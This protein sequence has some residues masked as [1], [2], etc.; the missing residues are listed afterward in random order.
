MENKHEKRTNQTDASFAAPASSVAPSDPAPKRY[1]VNNGFDKLFF[2]FSILFI[3]VSLVSLGAS[4]LVVWL[5][6]RWGVNKYVAKVVS[7]AISTTINYLGI[8]T[9]VFR[10]NKNKEDQRDE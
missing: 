3:A 5:L 8:K 9:L 6:T 10:I 7:M 2:F 1:V 4:T